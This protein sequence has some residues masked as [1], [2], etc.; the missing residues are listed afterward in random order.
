VIKIKNLVFILTVGLAFI[1]GL[2]C[3]LTKSLAVTN[4][5]VKPSTFKTGTNS[6]YVFTFSNRYQLF[7]GNWVK[8]I[9][10]KGTN[11]TKEILMLPHHAPGD[12]E[13]YLES[14]TLTYL[15]DGS[16]E[17]M[18]ILQRNLEPINTAN[19]VS[20]IIIP[21]EWEGREKEDRRLCKYQLFNPTDSAIVT[22]QMA[23][24]REPRLVSSQ[25]VKISKEGKDFLIIQLSI[26]S[27]N[28]SVNGKQK[29]LPLEPYIY[30]GQTM[31][32]FRFIGEALGAKIGFRINPS[33]KKV[34]SVS[35]ELDEVN[36]LLT[37]GSTTCQVNDKNT[38]LDVPPKIQDG[39]TVISLRFVAENLGCEVVWEPK[40]EAIKII[41][42]I[43]T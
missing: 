41:Y 28:Y 29:L 9:F 1:Y 38:T 7:R 21:P 39:Y 24:E 15:P 16:L 20:N 34:Y 42:P 13:P 8:L 37:I 10:P 18:F 40:T 19:D 17:L 33:T 22:Y 12:P 43:K 6:G 2:V 30:N 35:Y 26:G 27:L 32:P 11:Y 14:Q 4:F 5:T 31:T 3:P 23:T 25:A 36:I